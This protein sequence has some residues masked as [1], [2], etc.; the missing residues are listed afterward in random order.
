MEPSHAM[1]NHAGPSNF[2]NAYAHDARLPP[3]YGS[4]RGRGPGHRNASQ[5]GMYHQPQQQPYYTPNASAPYSGYPIGMNGVNGA[6]VNGHGPAHFSHH[7]QNG[8]SS[9]RRGVPNFQATAFQPPASPA[10]GSAH[11]YNPHTPPYIPPAP[12]MYHYPPAQMQPFPAAFSPPL[13]HPPYPYPSHQNLKS[14]LMSPLPEQ[15]MSSPRLR[16]TRT[17]SPQLLQLSPAPLHPPQH[18]SQS[19]LPA[20]NTIENAPSETSRSPQPE[21]RKFASPSFPK[22]EHNSTNEDQLSSPARTPANSKMDLPLDNGPAPH[23]EW[24][25]STLRPEDPADA[26]AIMISPKAKPPSHIVEGAL[27]YRPP[28]RPLARSSTSSKEISRAH[29]S[30]FPEMQVDGAEDKEEPAIESVLSHT[31]HVSGSTTETESRTSTA[32]DT[33]IPGSP[34][35]TN[36]SA[37]LGPSKTDTSVENNGQ[38]VSVSGT[39][40]PDVQLPK[41]SVSENLPSPALAGPSGPSS[42]IKKSWAS[43]LRAEGSSSK[44]SLPTSSVLGFSVPA[45]EM[46]SSHTILDGV[47][48]TKR[49]DLFQLLVNGPSAGGGIPQIR[50]RG[51]TNT[52]NMCF[53]NAVLQTLVY[54]PPF[55]RL[56]TELGKYIS[57][58]SADS[59]KWNGKATPLVNAIIEFLKEF[60]PKPKG[61]PKDSYEDDDEFDGIDSFIPTYVYDAMKKKSRFDN[62]GGGKQEDAEE[63]FGFFLD[64]IEEELLSISNVLTGDSYPKP[65]AQEQVST[66]ENNWLEVGKKNKA[67]VTRTTKSVDSPMTRIFGG[68]FRSAVKAPGQRESV[69]VEDWRLIRL[70]IQYEQVNSVEDA[71]GYI[72]HP[73]P[74]QVSS[75]TKGGA[76]VDAT[77]Q[78]LVET[79]PPI[80]VLQLK[81]FLYDTTA[82]DVVKVHKQIAF[83]P[84][85]EIPSDAVSPARRTA[86][87]IKYKLFAGESAAGGHYTLDV[88]HPNRNADMQAKPREG[89]I[90]ID[91]ELVS[92]L[93]VQDVF[94]NDEN[95]CAY[96]LFYRRIGGS[97][98][99]RAGQTGHRLVRARARFALPRRCLATAAAHPDGISSASSSSS[100]TVI[101]LSN[102][103]A[104]WEKLSSD[105][106]LSVHQQLEQ[107]QKK[108]WKTLSID[109]KKAAYYVAFG[110]HGPRTP[111]TPAGQPIK[112]FAGTMFCVFTALALFYGVRAAGGAPPKTMT[113]EWQEA[114]NEL[115]KEQQMNPITGISSEGYSGKG[116]VQGK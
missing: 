102:V 27:E 41:S 101:P 114:S 89:W 36:T 8:A 111:A 83:G 7:A 82:K 20:S 54:C 77:Q 15:M 31:E 112:I 78:V 50:P 100:S 10:L 97:Y 65:Q 80:L 96:L 64:T 22:L 21:I 39:T 88:L 58:T 95:R 5:N 68:K 28:I 98:A 12:P 29:V 86:H 59:T 113:K 67:V 2:A 105:E 48:S 6:P 75:V 62:M 13:H 45:I 116:F 107:L 24:V 42:S 93:R 72:L 66:E 53:A 17:S 26:F 38:E 47:S 18:R 44:T 14:P 69:M 33:F 94:G 87:P 91:D 85:L 90:R 30:S 73:Q 76:I 92:D 52:G 1:F 23:Q 46:D 32:P 63:F 110:P 115:A 81:R 25:I 103:E 40:N 49:S 4:G 35:S 60:K 16:K 9:A 37:S 56:F 11:V 61:N 109:E 19:S 51:L 71:L 99:A 55:F 3:Q 108:D 70:D 74:V 79:L 57:E 106:Q 84:E 34:F 43:L 104:Q